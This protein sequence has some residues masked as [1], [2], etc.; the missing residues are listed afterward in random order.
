MPYK[1]TV[2]YTK[3]RPTSVGKSDGVKT[4]FN[5]EES[6]DAGAEEEEEEEEVYKKVQEKK[7]SGSTPPPWQSSQAKQ[8]LE[9]LLKNHKEEIKKMSIKD[10]YLSSPKYS[11]YKYNNFKSNATRLAKKYE[12]ALRLTHGAKSR[13]SSAKVK[14][15]THNGL[16]GPV[17]KNRAESSHSRNDKKKEKTNKK[18][19][20][21]EI[22]LLEQDKQPSDSTPPP[23]K[24]SQAKQDLAELLKN[25]KEEMK[26]MSIKD[27]YLSS[28]KYSCYEYKNFKSN[29]TRLAKKH[30]IIFKKDDRDNWKDSKSKAILMKALM[31]K[32]SH[33]HNKTDEEIYNSSKHFQEFPF[34]YFKHNLNNLR[35]TAEQLNRWILEEEA[36]FKQEELAYPRNPLTIRNYPHWQYE[37]ECEM[38]K[39]DVRSG[40]AYRLSPLELRVTREEY[41][42][43][44]QIVFCGHIHAEKRA[45]READFWTSKRNKDA[46][47]Q[48]DKEDKQMQEDWEQDMHDEDMRCLGAQFKA[49]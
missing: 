25:Q 43:Y 33:I 4:T 2:H 18:N 32:K 28:P 48:R 13:P 40:L 34:E 39:E 24:S 27:I 3:Q 35:G 31:D 38:M 19:A 44:P 7:P 16:S 12:V 10:I 45:Q 41:Q 47:R 46:Q 42:Q 21:N 17:T 30:G 5:N 11:C 20:V 23:W 14:G 1:K 22:H 6:D 9:E 36:A 8:D 37:P 49:V 29:A 15:L 26:K